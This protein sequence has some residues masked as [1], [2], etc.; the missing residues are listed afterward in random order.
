[1]LGNPVA[2][3]ALHLTLTG[4]CMMLIKLRAL[5]RVVLDQ[6]TFYICESIVASEFCSPE[7]V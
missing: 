2:A 6:C 4:F 7:G 1:M 5:P 3:I